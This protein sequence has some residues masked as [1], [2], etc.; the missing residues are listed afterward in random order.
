MTH[1]ILYWLGLTDPAGAPYLWW[2][3]FGGR[4]ALGGALII[5]YLRHHTCHAQ[6]CWRLQRRTMPDGTVLCHRHAEAAR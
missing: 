6:G 2:S 3:G 5:T 4:V 1:A